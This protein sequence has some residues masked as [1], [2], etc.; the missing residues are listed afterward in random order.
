MKQISAFG[1]GLLFGLGILVSG[2]AEPAKVIAFLDLRGNWDPSLALVM[3]GAI[4]VTLWPMHWAKQHRS[5]SSLLG[6]PIQLPLRTDID[7]RLVLGSLLF[8]IGWGLAGICP[9]PALVLL[10]TGSLSIWIFFAALMLGM[11]LFH[12]LEQ[13]SAS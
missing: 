1:A 3:M 12:I 13:R 7:K 11:W 9:G 4:G 6:A 5:E 10:S 8:G 2:M